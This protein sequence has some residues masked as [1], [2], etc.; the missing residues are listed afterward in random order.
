MINKS[1]SKNFK[2][3]D[4]KI[5]KGEKVKNTN[6]KSVIQIS[7]IILCASALVIGGIS[8]LTYS[9][10]RN[11]YNNFNNGSN[12]SDN[13]NSSGGA[14]TQSDASSATTWISQ[15]TLSLRFSFTITYGSGWNSYN[16]SYYEYGTG[17]IY[18]AN[19]S[20]HTFYIATNLHVA[21]IISLMNKTSNDIKES[22]NMYE[23]SSYST[24]STTYSNLTSYV[25]FAQN[26]TGN[27]DNSI[28]I[29]YYKVSNPEL[30]YT[31]VTD[32]EFNSLFNSTS[33][34]Y[35]GVLGNSI[36]SFSGISD[37]AI[38]KYT[39]NPTNSTNVDFTNYNYYNLTEPSKT[40]AITNF[41]NW[42]STYFENP[43]KI[44]EGNME[45]L[46][47]SITSNLS[48]AGYP[49]YD[50]NTKTSSTKS[51]SW[52]P[53]SNFSVHET[54]SPI[55]ENN[56]KSKSQSY[57][58]EPIK[59]MPGSS[60]SSLSDNYYMSIGLLS[61]LTAD[62]YSGASGS[63]IVANFGTESNPD[64]EIVGIYWGAITYSNNIS[65][66]TMTW[67]ATN[68]YEISSTDKVSYN[69]TTTMNEITGYNK[70]Q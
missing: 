29:P 56:L 35:Y 18:S 58:S 57:Y 20:T 53:F 66:G 36:S 6:K 45:D 2:K 52:L 70:E 49:A 1:K 43:T 51:I 24:I 44:Y 48:M 32:N 54:Y 67:F 22:G 19:E 23:N 38:L 41:K 34:Q 59:Y 40:T 9:I 60:S 13:D 25:G 11:I 7:S 10:T 63:P 3:I 46:S 37:I 33:N 15:R 30:V 31:T 68:N 27:E 21:G 50:I 42:I 17:W 69:L 28:E 12:S 64:Y 16:T 61:E 8:F 65:Y 5:L 47:S 26:L 55:K 62:S 4:N 39:I 14:K